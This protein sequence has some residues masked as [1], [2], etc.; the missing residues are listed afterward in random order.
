MKKA[1]GTKR[2]GWRPSFFK[3]AVHRQEAS[4]WGSGSAT[5]KNRRAFTSAPFG[6]LGFPLET[7]EGRHSSVLRP[8]KSAGGSAL[9]SNRGS[10]YALPTTE[11]LNSVQYKALYSSPRS[12]DPD[13]PVSTDSAP[14][15]CSSV[16]QYSL[17]APYIADFGWRLGSLSSQCTFWL[18][19]ERKWCILPAQTLH[20]LTS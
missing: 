1:L 20:S 17:H 13:M 6:G 15:F 4:H 10:L 3:R 12:R 11:Y 19:Q 9:G 2:L 8:P 7:S 18:L 5:E 16:S 14:I